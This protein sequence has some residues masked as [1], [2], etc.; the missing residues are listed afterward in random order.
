MYVAT[1]GLENS[2]I[3]TDK[4]GTCRQLF[5]SNSAKPLTNRVNND[6]FS[7]APFQHL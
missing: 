5:H 7:L 2:Y 3:Q 4:D 6:P 1:C